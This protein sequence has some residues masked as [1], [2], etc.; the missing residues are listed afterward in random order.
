MAYR[1]LSRF[2][3]LLWCTLVAFLA[4]VAS[5]YFYV[6][7]ETGVWAAQE[8]RFH[9]FLLA[10]ELRQ[11]SDDLTRMVRTYVVTGER[12]YR[13][14][15]LEILDIRDGVK[16]R[17]E[18]YENIYWDLVLDNERPRPTGSP[19]ALLKRMEVAGFT[20]EEFSKL[21]EA[22]VRSDALVSIERAAMRFADLSDDGPPS[23]V[24]VKRLAAIR[25]VH[26]AT[27][28]RAKAM[29][30]KPIAEFNSL[31]DARTTAAVR[32]AERRALLLL[33]TIIVAGIL[34][35][36]TLWQLRRS[37]RRVVGGSVSAL[38]DVVSLAANGDLSVPVSARGADKDSIL[39]KLADM[40]L[41][42][43]NVEGQRK[44]TEK[45]LSEAERRFRSVVSA[46]SESICVVQD[47][48]IRF[49]NHKIAAVM[50]YSEEEMIDRPFIELIHPDD[51][52]AL[53]EK[54]F[55]RLDG[56]LDDTRSTFRVCTKG[57][58]VLPVESH[59]ANSEW[60]GRPATVYF[61]NLAVP[62]ANNAAQRG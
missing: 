62:V 49:V 8:S 51:R 16:P 4:C 60:R 58:D 54:Y 22:K 26:D 33:A 24:A 27:Y 14:H 11:S 53:M 9:S 40:Q 19:S 30:M 59:A 29:I 43:A 25:M 47:A 48:V 13:D 56:S 55:R 44:N 32:S 50:R 45:A 46:S 5:L 2:T 28:H 57:G 31:V 12:K 1:D 10:G 38:H 6:R 41:G 39:G 21:S 18:G 35:L 37:F 34:L 42:R 20:Q 15:F 3:A 23:E 7:A 61:L 36:A 52:P 17:P